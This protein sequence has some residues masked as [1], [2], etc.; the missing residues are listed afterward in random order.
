MCMLERGG[1][2]AGDAGPESWLQ[3][4]SWVAS[5][6]NHWGCLVPR[7]ACRFCA[8][9]DCMKQNR[10][11]TSKHSCVYGTSSILAGHAVLSTAAP[12][13]NGHSAQVRWA[14]AGHVGQP[15]ISLVCTSDTDAE[16]ST[17]PF[18]LTSQPAA[19]GHWLTVP[20]Y[21]AC[22]SRPPIPW[23]II[24]EEACLC[25]EWIGGGGGGG[26]TLWALT[27]TGQFRS[28]RMMAGQ[29]V[30]AVTAKA[31]HPVGARPDPIQ[32]AQ[33]FAEEGA[34]LAAQ[35]LSTDADSE[36]SCCSQSQLERHEGQ[37]VCPASPLCALPCPWEPATT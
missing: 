6:S 9:H 32:H 7:A 23:P 24:S 18:L 1:R 16:H 8:T 30:A 27:G 10:A 12:D 11:A 15:M 25:L 14:S 3:Q 29:H 22:E 21:T 26:Q 13:E 33:W 19:E 17:K 28:A 20:T 34:D 4:G 31:A 37:K 2:Q 35:G 36:Q 5:R